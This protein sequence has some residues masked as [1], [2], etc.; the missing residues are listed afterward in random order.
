MQIEFIPR[1]ARIYCGRVHRAGRK[2]HSENNQMKR[3]VVLVLSGLH[4][5]G[6][7][8][9]ANSFRAAHLSEPFASLLRRALRTFQ[10][11]GTDGRVWTQS[12][13]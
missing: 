6:T 12:D 5:L 9:V 8:L 4:H 13:H 2:S 7:F 11:T 3:A 1:R 10:H